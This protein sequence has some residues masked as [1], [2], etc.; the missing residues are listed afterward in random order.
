MDRHVMI[1]DMLVTVYKPL[2]MGYRTAYHSKLLIVNQLYIV[3]MYWVSVDSMFNMCHFFSIICY[4]WWW[5]RVCYSK[6]YSI[7]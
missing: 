5:S 7:S 4:H 6:I 3:S 2:S 1:L